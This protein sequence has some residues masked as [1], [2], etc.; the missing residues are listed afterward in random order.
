VQFIVDNYVPLHPELRKLSEA[1]FDAE[2]LRGFKAGRPVLTEVHPYVFTL[3]YVA[4]VWGWSLGRLVFLGS[5]PVT[6]AALSCTPCRIFSIEWCEKVLAEMDN[7][8]AWA[9]ATG[10]NVNRPNSM[11]N[12]GAI[13]DDMGM[14]AVFQDFTINYVRPLAAVLFPN[15]GADTLD[16]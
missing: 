12:Y 13:L 4:S 3:K 5:C 11:N 7:F 10:L 6:L 2:F 9:A 1:H 8:E 15:S 16:S 14:D